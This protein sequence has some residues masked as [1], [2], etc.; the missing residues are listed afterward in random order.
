MV[1]KE[2]LLEFGGKTRQVEL[3][4]EIL[5][6][7]AGSNEWLIAADI[8][9]K[10]TVLTPNQVN[11]YYSDAVDRSFVYVPE[12]YRGGLLKLKE[13]STSVDFDR[14]R[15]SLVRLPWAK[16]ELTTNE[17]PQLVRC[18]YAVNRVSMALQNS[19]LEP[20]QLLGEINR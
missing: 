3:A 13:L 6:V 10:E 17:Y 15:L 8:L 5:G 9:D 20:I 16:Q 1:D 18:R 19:T 4:V 7:P 11:W 14:L 2:V 12:D